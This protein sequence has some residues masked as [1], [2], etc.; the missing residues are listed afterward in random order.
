MLMAAMLCIQDD[1][2]LSKCAKYQASNI[3]TVPN[4]FELLST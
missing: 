3:E 1:L 4:V 2:S